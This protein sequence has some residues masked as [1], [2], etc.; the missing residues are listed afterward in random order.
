M[1]DNNWD[2]LVNDALTSNPKILSSPG[3]A[4]DAI[5]SP[6]PS[7][8][9][10]LLVHAATT[11]AAQQAAQDHLAE[12]QVAH[13]WWDGALHAVASGAEWMMKP[14][15]EVQRDYKYIH[16]LYA[17]HGIFAGTLGTMAVVGGGAFAVFCECG[18]CL[19]WARAD[20]G[21]GSV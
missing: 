11:Q 13:H 19:V 6:D 10:P 2:S 15:H 9:A 16:S 21:D 14:L 4:T 8:T 1:A 12:N 3:L 5:N 18:G 17:R 20:G 7:V